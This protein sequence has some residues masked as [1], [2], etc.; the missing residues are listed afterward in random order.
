M[1]NSYKE[2]HWFSACLKIHNGSI[3]LSSFLLQ[4][5]QGGILVRPFPRRFIGFGMY[6]CHQALHFLLEFQLGKLVHSDFI[7]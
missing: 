5:L 6:I 2:G 7:G 1:A 3:Q 4:S